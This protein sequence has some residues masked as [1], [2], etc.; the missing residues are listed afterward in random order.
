[1]KAPLHLW[2]AGGVSLLWNGQ[3]GYDYTMTQMKNQHYLGM[4]SEA[5]RGFL[6]TA[7]FWFDA[8]WAVGVWCAIFGSV[9][10]LAR[11]RLARPAFGTALLGLACGAAYSFGI[12]APNMQDITGARAIWT[13]TGTCIIM[14]LLWRYAAAMTRR[15]ILR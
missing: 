7:P 9:L 8:A 4:L 5:Q 6:N 15:G 12:A 11:A 10:L 13:A 14:L 2:I 1:M 3:G